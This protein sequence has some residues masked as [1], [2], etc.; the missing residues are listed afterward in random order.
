[1]SG[2]IVRLVLL[3]TIMLNHAVMACD[4][5]V[6]HLPDDSHP[7]TASGPL[8]HND[9]PEHQHLFS[10]DN[11]ADDSVGDA[12]EHHPSHAHV[13]CGISHIHSVA[14]SATGSH[15]NSKA[16]IALIPVSYSPPVPPP[17]V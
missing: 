1:M 7:Y 16:D 5:L 6:M 4:A 15:A 10:S 14:L 8:A 2:K 11:N 13:S 9:M 3:L 17:N 12:E